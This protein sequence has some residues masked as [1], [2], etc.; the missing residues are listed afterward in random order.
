[1]IEYM[2]ELYQ[3]LKP[4]LLGPVMLLCRLYGLID[5]GN[6][7]TDWFELALSDSTLLK[8]NLSVGIS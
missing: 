8:C 3:L 1:M 6:V 5:S 7:A 4:V 2:V